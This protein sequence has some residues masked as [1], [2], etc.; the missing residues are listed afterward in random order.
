MEE[1]LQKLIA[2]AGLCSRRKAEEW[3]QQGRVAVNGTPARLGGR[4]DPDRDQIT[5]DGCPLRQPETR[6]YLMVHKP[7]GYTCSLADRHAAHL[8]TE[9]T[10]DCGVRV[11]PVGRLDVDSEGLLL[12]TNDGEFA[13]RI[14]HPSHQVDKR[15]HVTVEGYYPGAE[16]MI[17]AITS[18]DGEPVHGARTEVLRRTGTRATLAVVIHEGRKRQIR[19]MCA[20]AGLEVERLCRLEE[21]GLKLGT[22]PPGAWRELTEEEVAA[23]MGE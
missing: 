22:L 8:V 4:A 21:H 12:M 9:L 5:V 6:R 20:K 13:H 15:Y 16:K 3:I 11:Y 7:R 23:V 14:L 1:R 2:A 10:A 18:L 19:R 17:A